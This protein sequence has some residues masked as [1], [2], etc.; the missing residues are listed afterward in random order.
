GTDGRTG[1]SA[2]CIRAVRTTHT[3]PSQAPS[4]DLKNFGGDAERGAFRERSPR[5]APISNTYGVVAGDA[6]A[7]AEAAAAASERSVILWV[8]V[9]ALAACLALCLQR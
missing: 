1:H 7:A 8:L 4:P 3:L 5:N 9:A 2:A 6:A